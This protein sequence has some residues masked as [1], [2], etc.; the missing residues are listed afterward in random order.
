MIEK[1]RGKTAVRKYTAKNKAMSDNKTSSVK[2]ARLSDRRAFSRMAL[3]P[4]TPAQE[5]VF[6]PKVKT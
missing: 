5:P 6:L 3:L 4:K 1:R 2:P